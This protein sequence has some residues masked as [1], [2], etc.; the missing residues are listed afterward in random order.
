MQTVNRLFS[1]WYSLW[2]DLFVIRSVTEPI[3]DR[4]SSLTTF[5]ILDE[6]IFIL[7]SHACLSL[8]LSGRRDNEM[9]SF[10]FLLLFNKRFYEH[11]YANIFRFHSYVWVRS[12]IITENL[13][14]VGVASLHWCE[15]SQ[16]FQTRKF[17]IIRS[18]TDGIDTSGNIGFYL[19]KYR[20]NSKSYHVCFCLNS[21]F[22]SQMSM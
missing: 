12:S 7:Y 21:L 20:S 9:H 13:F 16:N 15:M 4:S 14:W 22:G 1:V 5:R 11:K 18:C 19:W 10:V 8:S 6:L 3:S 2:S 17:S